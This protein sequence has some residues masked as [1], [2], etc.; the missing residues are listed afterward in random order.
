MTQG[1]IKWEY[2]SVEFRDLYNFTTSDFYDCDISKINIKNGSSNY[3]LGYL[4]YTKFGATKAIH[5]IQINPFSLDEYRKKIIKSFLII[6][7]VDQLRW[8]SIT[9]K[10][11]TLKEFITALDSELSDDGLIKAYENYSDYLTHQ[12]RIFDSAKKKGITTNTAAGRQKLIRDICEDIL[13]LQSC[14]HVPKIN[15]RQVQSQATIP[16]EEGDLTFHLNLYTSAFTELTRFI[17]NNEKYPARINLS[18]ESLAI[19]PDNQWCLPKS[20]WDEYWTQTKPRNI[21]FDYENCRY[22]ASNKELSDLFI[23]YPHMEIPSTDANLSQLRSKCKRRLESA[24][25]NQFSKTRKVLISWAVR[26]YFMHFL[27]ITGMN[28]AVAAG[29]KFEDVEIKNGGRKFKAIKIRAKRKVVTFEIQNLFL[30]HF[31]LYLKLRKQILLSC[32]AK[33]DALFLL[34]S[35]Q[36]E[37]ISFKKNGHISSWINSHNPMVETMPTVTSKQYRAAK[38]QWISQ[39]HGAELSSFALQHSLKTNLKHYNETTEK[40]AENEITDYFEK[41]NTVVLD[42]KENLITKTVSGACTNKNSPQIDSNTPEDFRGIKPDCK[43]FE[44]CLFCD[45]Y[46]VHANEEDIRKLLSMHF[47]ITNLKEV[48]DTSESYA[49]TLNPTLERINYI[50][51]KINKD[52]NSEVDIDLIKEDVYENE[53][54]SSYWLQKYEMMDMLGLI[55]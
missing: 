23:K 7:E 25:S 33:N 5:S 3:P 1:L 53:N 43:R 55:S 50:I 36:G 48:S 52:T 42:A 13:G 18:H 39:K 10:Y 49:R 46:A 37:V 44:G 2:E 34:Y 40:I 45:N 19:C 14:D 9:T 26:S 21:T 27:I 22:R 47:L 6:I 51:V 31:E 41:L 35:R 30:K 29:I 16:A 8:T 32:N 28:D 54:L 24:N 17:L 4:A 15:G 20:K 12:T 11:S 38:G